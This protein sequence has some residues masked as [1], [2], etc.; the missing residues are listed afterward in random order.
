M[1]HITLL[2]LLA[3]A[4]C[5]ST[6]PSNQSAQT[7]SPAVGAQSHYLLITD[8]DSAA[9]ADDLKN[10]G[11][12]VTNK[13]VDSYQTYVSTNNVSLNGADTQIVGWLNADQYD[14]IILALGGVESVQPVDSSWPF[15]RYSQFTR[16]MSILNSTQYQGSVIYA[17]VPNGYAWAYASNNRMSLGLDAVV[18]AGVMLTGSDLDSPTLPNA[19]G[20][21][22]IADALVTYL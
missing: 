21:T 1:R 3:L 8:Q 18:D 19:S 2:S 11:Y 9:L 15:H 22:K 14:G 13:V 5:G 20:I 10:R 4:A 16:F 12:D 7:S 17:G 6:G